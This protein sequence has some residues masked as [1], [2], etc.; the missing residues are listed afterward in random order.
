M[1]IHAFVRKE[2]IE[3]TLF[4]LTIEFKPNE[5][6][7]C[8]AEVTHAAAIERLLS[9]TEGYVEYRAVEGAISIPIAGLVAQAADTADADPV[10][11]L[12]S[13]T[14]PDEIE[15]AEDRFVNVA[16]VARAAFER[17]GLSLDFWNTLADED[18]ATRILAEV[19]T[20]RAGLKT[21]D[22]DDE[23][24]EQREREESA[25][26]LQE[27][28]DK[29]KAEAEAL[30]AAGAA[31]GPVVDPL[32]LTDGDTTI[33]I[34]KMTAAEVRAMAAEHKVELPKGNST[35]LVDLR[36]LLAK[37]LKGE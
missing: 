2:P 26:E 31:P 4:G 6:K 27:A 21:T 20:L 35:K 32:V 5:H 13:T 9:I 36:N 1:L 18:R 7:H 25:R 14:L 22:E 24:I 15:L 23:A 29:A 16:D 17:S 3:V 28:Q 19:D 37:G 30:E 34:G 8:V 33:D 11:P 10:L 12:G